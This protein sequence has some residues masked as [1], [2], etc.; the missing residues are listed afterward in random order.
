MMYWTDWGANPKVEKAEMDGSG[1]RSIIMGNLAWPHG[2]TLDQATDRL[3]WADAKL[4]NIEMSDLDGGNRQIV[5]SSSAGIHPYGLTIYQ[6]ILYWTDWNNRSIS[7]YNATSGEADM[8]IPDLQ[9]PMDIHVFDPS[10]MFSGK[11]SVSTKIRTIASFLSS[12]S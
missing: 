11:S 2:L 8:V 3:Y 5:L 6:D 1:R 10:L 4:D 12:L 7:S 9:Q